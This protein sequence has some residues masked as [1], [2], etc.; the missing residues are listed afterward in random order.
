MKKKNV[1]WLFTIFLG[2]STLLF[3]SCEKID[4]II[5][6]PDTQEVNVGDTLWIHHLPQGEVEHY[7]AGPLAIGTDGTIYYEAGGHGMNGTNWDPVQIYAVDKSD[8]S[9]KWKSEPLM[10][11]HKNGET[12]MVGDNGNIYVSSEYKLYSINP[13]NGSFNWVWEVPQTLT[14]AN[15][16]QVYAYGELGYMCLTNNNDVV[17]KTMG[18]GSY[19]RAYYCLTSNGTLKWVQFNVSSS[20]QRM[21]VGYDGMIYDVTTIDNVYVLTS[22]NP[23]NG[24]L[25]WTMQVSINESSNN[26]TFTPDGD[27]ITFTDYD[28]LSRIDLANQEVLWQTNISVSK[29]KFIS[30]DGSIY[31]YSAYDGWSV[32]NPNTGTASL[33]GNHIP[34]ADLNIDDKK[35]FYGTYNDWHPYLQVTDNQGNEI[36]RTQTELDAST[37]TLGNNTVYFRASDNGQESIFALQTGTGL[38]HSGWPRFSHDSRNTWN[39]NKW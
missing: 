20:N 38:A 30:S 24:E 22:R 14:D 5:E 7:I 32:V 11:W 9:L 31:V 13:S 12:I 10:S 35:Q 2:M 21:S 23:D 18:A 33:V 19:Q 16:N 3:E 28:T 6:P 4:D 17:I 27:I 25:N 26:I 36:W 29:P 1:F 8:G 37:I 39:Y 34:S 15:N